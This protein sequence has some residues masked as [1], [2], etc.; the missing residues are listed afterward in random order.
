[1]HGRAA[2][3]RA[4]E[5]LRLWQVWWLWGLAAA[6]AIAGLT[7]AAE[8]AREAGSAVQGDLLEVLRLAVYWG[9]GWAVWK[10]AR[11]VSRPLWT[12]LARLAV[13]TGVALLI[14]L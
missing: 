6:A 2:E 7:A 10:T 3:R 8:H 9:W 11:N 14:L 1:L 12:P 5:R 4:V 13:L